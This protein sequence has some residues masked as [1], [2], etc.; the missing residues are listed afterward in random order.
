[1]TLF[2]YARWPTAVMELEAVRRFFRFGALQE[3]KMRACDDLKHSMA[4][5]TRAVGTP[6]QLLSC[7]NIAQISAMLAAGGGERAM[8]KADRKA[9]YKHL[10]IDTAD[11]NADIIAFGAPPITYGTASSRGP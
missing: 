4:N 9:S 6:T 10:P 8:F 3:D 5:L 11:Q 1:M 2:R 7:G